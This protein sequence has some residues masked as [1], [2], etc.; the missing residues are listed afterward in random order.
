MCYA[1]CDVIEVSDGVLNLIKVSSEAEGKG[2][3]AGNELENELKIDFCCF[4]EDFL[5]ISL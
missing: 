4:D 2:K 3:I 1:D 5:S